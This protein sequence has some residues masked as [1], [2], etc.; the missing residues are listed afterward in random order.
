[1]RPRRIGGRDMCWAHVRPEAC[2]GPGVDDAD[3]IRIMRHHDRPSD[4]L[5]TG[6]VPAAPAPVVPLLSYQRE[7]VEAEDRFRWN[8][9][10]RQTGK[11]FTKALRRLLRGLARRRNQIFLSAGLRQCTELM[12]KVRQHCQ[13]LQV[14]CDY[15]GFDALAELRERRLEVTLPG[16]VR[17]IG[18]PANPATARGFSGD[19][20][21][22]EFAMHG[23][24]RAIWAALFPTLLRGEG[25][26]DVAST[27][28]GRGNVFHELSFNEAFGRS[29]VT[30]PQAVAQGLEADV[31][32]VRRAMGDEELF[33]QEFLCEFLDESTAFLTYDQ[34]RG[35]QSESCRP[36]ASVE[37]LAEIAASDGVAARHAGVEAGRDWFAGVDV[38]RKHDL[39]VIWVLQRSG[40]PGCGPVSDSATAAAS[41]ARRYVTVGLIELSRA[42]FTRQWDALAG[43]LRL[44]RLRRC[45]IDA[46]GIGMALA[47]EAERVFGSGRVE[48]VTFTA[49]FKS[50]V[51]IALRREVEARRLVIPANDR[52]LHDWRSVERDVTPIGHLK[53]TAPRGASGHAD[54]FWAA[55]LALHAAGQAPVEKSALTLPA[56]MFSARGA[57]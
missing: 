12:S 39:T 8:C 57:W 14:A 5:E 55:A 51:A 53:L 31:E 16:G 21:L 10:A 37:A 40:G 54:R 20:L 32:A 48:A 38:G 45:V 1:M 52:V 22:D 41:D 25:E 42:P 27:P 29:I 46:G 26:L 9:W 4:V 44:G 17:I 7:D 43:L 6:A 24:D 49:P 2:L 3:L 33:R 47:E 36:A 11:S 18:L 34:I 30:L 35:C 19:V 28:K 13:A 23:D 15:H 56:G 50:A